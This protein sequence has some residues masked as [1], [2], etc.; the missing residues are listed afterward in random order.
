MA[1]QLLNANLLKVHTMLRSGLR[2]LRVHRAPTSHV[3]PFPRRHPATPRRINHKHL[4]IL[5]LDQSL[6]PAFPANIFATTLQ[7][8][9]LRHP[10]DVPLHL[11]EP[12]DLI[13]VGEAAQVGARIGGGQLDETDV[14]VLFDL[15][16]GGEEGVALEQ[17]LLGG[18]QGGVPVA[19]LR[20]G[21]GDKGGEQ[22]GLV[23]LEVG[24]TICG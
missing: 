20:A 7:Q 1:D 24:E 6:R 13:V 12:A 21:I 17:L 4:R 22:A 9:G 10:D 15:E 19:Q 23:A 2:T 3:A 8:L 14:A 16:V 18:E 11:H 5:G